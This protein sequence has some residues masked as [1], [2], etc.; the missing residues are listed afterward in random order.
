MLPAPESAPMLVAV[1]WFF[2]ASMTCTIPAW[3]FVTKTRSLTWLRFGFVD[4][5]VLLL[6]PPPQAHHVN[7]TEHNTSKKAERFNRELPRLALNA[8]RPSIAER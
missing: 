6:L 1:I 3:K 2:V 7:T 8:E 4:V 5:L